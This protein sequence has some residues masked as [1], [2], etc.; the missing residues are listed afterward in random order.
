MEEHF[1]APPPPP[2]PSRGKVISLTSDSFKANRKVINLVDDAELDVVGTGFTQGPLP[3]KSTFC[4]NAE[5]TKISSPIPAANTEFSVMFKK[6]G[7]FQS[8]DSTIF[9]GS[10]DG[11][12]TAHTEYPSSYFLIA[13]RFMIPGVIDEQKVY[14]TANSSSLSSVE[15]SFC[16]NSGSIVGFCF[17]PGEG[18]GYYKKS[19]SSILLEDY[20]SDGSSH[21]FEGGFALGL[22]NLASAQES[23]IV[24][25]YCIDVFNHKLTT[26][27]VQE[28]VTEKDA[29]Y[30]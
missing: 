13:N 8:V 19:G 1:D 28:W 25:Y 10:I 16:N 21:S 24:K 2:P 17:K 29:L 5:E 26:D 30:D 12:R 6:H 4:I 7:N 23:N 27:E 20:G 15:T 9:M 3:N 18:Y 14:I 11:L 22:V